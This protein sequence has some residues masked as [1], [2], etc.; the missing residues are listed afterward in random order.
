ML[1]PWFL[2][3]YEKPPVC[4]EIDLFFNNG[5]GGDKGSPVSFFMVSAKKRREKTSGTA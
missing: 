4:D 1:L 2:I 3:T 5:F